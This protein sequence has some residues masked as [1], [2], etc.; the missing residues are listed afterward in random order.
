MTSSESD[1]DSHRRHRKRDKKQ[2]RKKKKKSSSKD[3][4]RHRRDTYNSSDE[5]DSDDSY[6]QRRKRDKKRHRKDDRRRPSS[7]DDSYRERNRRKK[8]GKKRESKNER[9]STHVEPKQDD[10]KYALTE[11]LLTAFSSHPALVED[12]PIM[13][14][15]LAGGTTFDLSQMIDVGAANNLALVFSTMESFGIRKNEKGLWEWQKPPG[16]N[17]RNDLVLI[18]VVRALLDDAGLTMDAIS[19]YEDSVKEAQL[20]LISIQKSDKSRDAVTHTTRNLFNEFKDPAFRQEIT[21]LCQMILEGESIALDDIPDEKLK[22]SLEQLFQLVGLEKSEME[23][24]SYSSPKSNQEENDATFGFGIPDND[25]QAKEL[26]QTVMTICNEQ[27]Q[28]AND[29]KRHIK[30]PL[31]P[32]EYAAEDS[33]DDVGPSVPGLVKRESYVPPEVIKAQA[34]R[35]ELQL[36]S[37]AAGHGDLS[38]QMGDSAREEWMLVPG[39]FDFLSAIKAAPST[40]SRQF[41]NKKND[42]RFPGSDQPVDST[43]KAEIDHIMNAHNEARGPSLMDEHKRLKAEQI[44]KDAGNQGWKWDRDKD[45]DAGRRVDKNALQMVLGGAADGLKS[46]FAGGFTGM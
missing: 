29:S 14:I 31:L 21:S 11:A 28:T 36:K 46:K 3:K 39:K 17:V 5:S 22:D 8:E 6:R 40:R 43:V 33:D 10:P 16:S 4:K 9:Y 41:V 19:T 24:E 34:A 26:L 18:R 42:G 27:P 32:H 2:K 15:R 13:L 44:Q 1:D 37:I 45:L 20:N 30:G 25:N 23:L 12:L 7:D 38:G 35:R